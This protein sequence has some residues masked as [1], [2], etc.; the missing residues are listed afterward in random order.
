MLRFCLLLFV[1]AC[2]EAGY[3]PVEI[4]VLNTSSVTFDKVRINTSGGE[5]TYLDIEPNNYSSYQSF[6]FAYRYAYVH[7]Q[8]GEEE[9][10][11]QPID[12]VGEEKVKAGKYTYEINVD[13]AEY[14]LGGEMV[15]D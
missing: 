12:Y 10:V 4:R 11:L 2:E 15:R 14:W 5:Q 8:A 9:Y 6:D 13:S 1:F 3:G 7:V